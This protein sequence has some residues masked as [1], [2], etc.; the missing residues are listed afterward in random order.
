MF[1]CLWTWEIVVVGMEWVRLVYRRGIERRPVLCCVAIGH[2]VVMGGTLRCLVLPGFATGP[3]SVRVCVC[4]RGMVEEDTVGVEWRCVLE[5]EAGLRFC[6]DGA[7]EGMLNCEYMEGQ[8]EE[9]GSISKRAAWQGAASVSE[10]I[11]D[12]IVVWMDI[13]EDGNVDYETRWGGSGVWL[14]VCLCGMGVENVRQDGFGSC[15][16]EA[17]LL[18]G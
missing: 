11:L 1:V 13:R 17:C 7:S 16:G 12:I 14:G 5:C 15:V 6:G 2:C 10:W 8:L 9:R 18:G 3:A 4:V